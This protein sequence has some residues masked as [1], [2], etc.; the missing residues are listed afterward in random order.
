LLNKAQEAG[1]IP[2]Y[3]WLKGAWSSLT[4]A[5]EAKYMNVV[6]M[7]GIDPTDVWDL[8]KAEMEGWKTCSSRV[9]ASPETKNPTRPRAR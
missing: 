5:G 2:E 4:P 7:T 3:I 1:D 9:A 8:T 6:Y